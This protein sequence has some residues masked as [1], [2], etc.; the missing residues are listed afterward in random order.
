MNDKTSL[1]SSLRKPAALAVIATFVLL[2]V[3]VLWPEPETQPLDAPNTDASEGMSMSADTH[4]GHEGH[5]EMQS[6]ATHTAD[7]HP[8]TRSA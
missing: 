2:T 5:G 7:S 1:L 3:V 8:L 6:P 4:T